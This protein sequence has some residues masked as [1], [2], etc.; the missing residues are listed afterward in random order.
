MLPL[1]QLITEDLITDLATR[2][3]FRYGKEI[4]REGK[5]TTEK[6]NTFNLVT[7]VEF[8]GSNSRTVELMSTVK[9][10]RWKCTCSSRKDLF[11]KHVAGAGLALISE[12]IKI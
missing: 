11:C 10:F 2:S 12:K 9:G 8:R 3:N 1:R 5:F 4:A 7:R 6:S